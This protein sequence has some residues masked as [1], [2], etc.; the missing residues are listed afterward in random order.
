MLGDHRIAAKSC[1][2]A[3]GL[4]ETSFVRLAH[5]RTSYA[6]T[7][8]DV[9]HHQIIDIQFRKFHNYRIRALLYAG[10]PNWRVL[11]SIVVQ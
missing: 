1:T 7:V 4:D 11:G 10:K 2:T 6:T 9:A 8:C 3:I 5:A